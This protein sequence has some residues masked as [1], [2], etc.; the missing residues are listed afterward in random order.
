MKRWNSRT[1]DQKSMNNPDVMEQHKATT[2]VAC[3]D[4]LEVLTKRIA[5]KSAVI[6]HQDKVWLAKDV[7]KELDAIV[8]ELTGSSARAPN[9]K[10]D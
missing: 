7:S 3:S 9:V 4:W 10:A 1:S 8:L 6:R 5:N 2:P